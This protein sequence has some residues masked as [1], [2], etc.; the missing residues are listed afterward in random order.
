M[1]SAIMTNPDFAEVMFLVAFILFVI[2]VVVH[3]T[4][5]AWTYWTLLLAAGLAC[6]S[7][8]FLAS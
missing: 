3:I 7:L 6:L 2:E 5:P 8:G 1:L 4:Q